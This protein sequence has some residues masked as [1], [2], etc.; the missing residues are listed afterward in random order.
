MIE[1]KDFFY[2][3]EEKIP[4]HSG[5]EETRAYMRWLDMLLLSYEAISNQEEAYEAEEEN[6]EKMKE[7]LSKGLAVLEQRHRLTVG[8]QM[9]EVKGI[10]VTNLA[11]HLGLRDYS[12]LVFL[13][14]LA[15][16]LEERYL[17]IYQQLYE[18]EETITGVTVALVNRLYELL[19]KEQGEDDGEMFRQQIESNPAFIIYQQ[20]MSDSG[21][22]DRITLHPSIVALCNGETGL[23][24]AERR[25]CEEGDDRLL[26]SPAIG[27]GQQTEQLTNLLLKENRGGDKILVHVTGKPGSGKKYLIQQAWQSDRILFI[28]LENLFR[29]GGEESGRLLKSLL[30]RCKCLD[31][32]PVFTNV[33]LKEN[34][35][36]IRMMVDHAFDFTDLL[37]LTSTSPLLPVY[38][39]L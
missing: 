31:L 33:S 6:L 2:T 3:G 34:T 14:V 4:F 35:E 18:K 26:H 12:F 5:M 1:F 20:Q 11:A 27:L 25:V 8:K 38:I 30:I 13:L 21:R 22:L 29:Q 7:L 39:L 17:L 37:L 10:G 24:E 9:E 32:L 15:P 36:E 19:R 28:N 16:Q 23:S